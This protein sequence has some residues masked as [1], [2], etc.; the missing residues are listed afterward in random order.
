M[1][2]TTNHRIKPVIGKIS[3][4]LVFLMAANLMAGM[5]ALAADFKGCCGCC[6]PATGHPSA[7]SHGMKNVNATDCCDT[8][9]RPSCQ[10]DKC[11]GSNLPESLATLDKTS[12][13][14]QVTIISSTQ[15]PDVI[16]TPYHHVSGWNLPFTK[17]S[18]PIFISTCSF[19]C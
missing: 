17:R 6:S 16:V 14:P 9:K 8:T 10:M 2:K 19:L 7:N 5:G 3:I 4:I 13:R 11:S 12:P 1:T 18:T 15:N